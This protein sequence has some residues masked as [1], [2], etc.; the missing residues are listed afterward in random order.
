[1]AE[2]QDIVGGA[3]REWDGLTR[4]HQP[5]PAVPTVDWEAEL[6]VVLAVGTRP[7]SGYQ[8]TIE[9][10]TVTDRQ[11]HVSAWEERNGGAAL[12]IVT[13]PVHA[14]AM[15]LHD[16]GDDLHLVQRITLWTDN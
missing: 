8:V 7:A 10:L 13:N 15:P 11:L 12:D 16:L 5:A 9:R 14:V 1:M 2:R 6:V 3:E 4:F